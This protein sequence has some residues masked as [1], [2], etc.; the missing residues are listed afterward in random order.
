MHVLVGQFAQESNSF[1]ELPTEVASFEG[2]QCLRGEQVL[3]GLLGTRG[4]V[5]GFLDGLAGT[6]DLVP[7]PTVAAWAPSGGPLSTDCYEHLLQ[8]IEQAATPELDGVLLALHGAMMTDR[9]DDADGELLRR[10]RARVGPG[11]PI[12]ATLDLHANVTEA[13]VEHADGLIGYDTYPHIDLYEVGERAARMLLT[14]VTTGLRP[15]TILAK[16]PMIVPAEGMDTSEEPMISLVR[17][18]IRLRD[19]EGVLSSS[20]FAVQPWLDVPDTGFSAIAVVDRPDVID[21]TVEAL[22][23]IA[24]AAWSRRDAFRAPLVAVDEGIAAALASPEG[25]VVLSDPAD[26]TGAGSAGDSAYVIARLLAAEPDRMCIACIVAPRAVAAAHEAGTGATITTEIGAQVDPRWTE[27]V[28]ITAFVR[29]LSSGHFRYRGGK[30]RGLEVSMGP[31]AVLQVGEVFILVME[32]PAE[33]FDPGMYEAVGLPPQRAA[34]VL[35]RSA[36]QFRDSY[37]GIAVD[38]LLLD[39]P[40]PS[41]ARLERL[42]W[43]KVPRPIYPLDDIDRVEVATVVGPDRVRPR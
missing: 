42:P 26:A 7:V 36:T 38:T 43:Q 32:R 25:P 1:I 2:Q 22:Q 13:M 40:G 14:T 19:G 41:T 12:I 31:A 10:I 28:T 33:T 35:V 11:V 3:T 4:T 24:E 39:A 9:H 37:R 16:V 20:V 8:P 6:E 21:V 29:T 30:S 27:P 15:R 34:V 17:Q 5:A 18:A 23:G